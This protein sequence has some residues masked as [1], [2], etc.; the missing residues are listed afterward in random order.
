MISCSRCRCPCVPEQTWSILTSANGPTTGQSSSAKMVMPQAKYFRKGKMLHVSEEWG[1]V[2]KETALWAASW[3]KKEENDELHVLEQRFS[4]SLWRAL[5]W[6]V[7]ILTH[8]SSPPVLS[9][10]PAEK[11][12]VSSCVR[13]WLLTNANPSQIK[14]AFWHINVTKE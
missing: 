9:L 10:C 3:E 12:W 4:W 1:K 8:K 2:E 11:E 13:V 6:S 14:F 5:C 7:S